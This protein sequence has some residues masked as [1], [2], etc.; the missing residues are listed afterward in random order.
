MSNS[1][2]DIDKIVAH[3]VKTS[4]DDFNTMIVLLNSMCTVD[5]TKEW[6]EKIKNLQKWIK[7][8]L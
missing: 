5:Y 6:I 7:Q 1:P 3:W 8:M 4:D 2:L